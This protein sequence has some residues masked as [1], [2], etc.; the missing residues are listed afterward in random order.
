MKLPAC[1]LENLTRVNLRNFIT[2][3]LMKYPLPFN[4]RSNCVTKCG[5]KCFRFRVRVR[6]RVR[7]LGYCFSSSNLTVI[8]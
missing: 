7:V 8:I 4:L 6:V 2:I 3:A 5:Q 1:I